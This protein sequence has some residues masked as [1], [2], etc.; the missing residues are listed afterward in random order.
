MRKIFTFIK[1]LAI[2]AFVFSVPLLIAVFVPHSRKAGLLIQA[3]GVAASAVIALFAIM[4]EQIR[5]RFFGPKLA[6]TLFKPQGEITYNVSRSD[7]ERIPVRYYHFKVVNKRKGLVA[8]NVQVVLLSID[9]PY[10]GGENQLTSLGGRLPF[11]WAFR[12]RTAGLEEKLY[13]SNIGADDLCDLACLEEGEREKLR[14]LAD[15]WQVITDQVLI[16]PNQ[17]AVIEAVAVADNAQSN[18]IR[19]ELFWDGQWPENDDDALEH[20]VIKKA[21]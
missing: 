3:I 4:G 16:G 11:P 5:A 7:Q 21:K 19:L 2:I 15:P 18:R 1:W 20:I 12:E 13:Y 8:Q 6:L 17:K 9:S 14:I 10:K